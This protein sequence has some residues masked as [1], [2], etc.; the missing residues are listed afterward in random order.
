MEAD[1]LGDEDVASDHLLAMKGTDFIGSKTSHPKPSI[2]SR[3]AT[4]SSSRRKSRL[5]SMG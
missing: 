3:E 2:L 4:A 5:L 1:L